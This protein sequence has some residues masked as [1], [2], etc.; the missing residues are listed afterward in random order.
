MEVSM[1]TATEARELK[2]HEPAKVRRPPLQEPSQGPTAII[3]KNGK[4]ENVANGDV[5]LDYE[6]RGS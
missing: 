1:R 4:I 6:M 2:V 5:C 3:F